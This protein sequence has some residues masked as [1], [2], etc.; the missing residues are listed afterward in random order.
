MNL[1]GRAGQDGEGQNQSDPDDLHLVSTELIWTGS[2]RVLVAPIMK[3]ST[4]LSLTS[5]SQVTA[6]SFSHSSRPSR[7]VAPSTVIFAEER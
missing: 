1:P 7:S 6:H 4:S 5:L 3:T 2:V